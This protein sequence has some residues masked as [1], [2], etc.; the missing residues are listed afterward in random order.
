[1][2]E[3]KG[4]AT[5]PIKAAEMR[6]LIHAGKFAAW[7]E[8]Q[9]ALASFIESVAAPTH[10]FPIDCGFLADAHVVDAFEDQP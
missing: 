1:M 7:I 8:T 3:T 4:F 2:N 6:Q 10:P 9:K 5:Q